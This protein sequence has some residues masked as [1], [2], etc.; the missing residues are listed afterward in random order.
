M[1]AQV[2]EDSVGVPNPVWQGTRPV[3][4]RKRKE[5]A[6]PLQITGF[7][8]LVF[9]PRGTMISGSSPKKGVE[10][11]Q[12]NSSGGERVGYTKLSLKSIIVIPSPS[13]QGP[14]TILLGST[15]F[16]SIPVY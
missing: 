9:P 3:Q 15:I 1:W 4:G 6:S 5:E 10:G 7:P 2:Y 13:A 16:P 14:C 8:S 11:L 12:W